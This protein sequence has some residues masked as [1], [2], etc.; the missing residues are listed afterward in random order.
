MMWAITAVLVLGFALILGCLRAYYYFTN[1]EDKS[2]YE[3][4]IKGTSD[5]EV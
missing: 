4:S 5:D 3:G 2:Y 1:D